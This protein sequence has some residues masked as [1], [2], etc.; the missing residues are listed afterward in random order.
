MVDSARTPADTSA[1]HSRVPP[2]EEG[3]ALAPLTSWKIGGPAAFFVEPRNPE[4]LGACLRMAQE[5]RLE[6]LILGGGSNLL[7]ADE[8]FPGLV[9]RYADT[10]HALVIAEEQARARF[11]ARFPLARAARTL[12]AEGWAGLEWAEGIPGTIGGAVAGNAGAFGGEI[13]SALE[14]LQIYS[15]ARGLETLTPADCGFSYRSSRF[16]RM[17]AMRTRRGPIHRI[18]EGRRRRR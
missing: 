2:V 17:P 15:L 12:A 7:V 1:M 14:E 5:R 18:E 4:E 9:L 13:S 11:G 10:T 16:R 8:G 3:R 6:V